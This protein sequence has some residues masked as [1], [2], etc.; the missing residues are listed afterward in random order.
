MKG[1]QVDFLNAP[2]GSLEFEAFA[3]SEKEIVFL[4]TPALKKIGTKTGAVGF[5]EY[6][7]RNWASLFDGVIVFREQRAATIIDE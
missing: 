7:S 2:A 3:K 5:A 6:V 4:D 1:V